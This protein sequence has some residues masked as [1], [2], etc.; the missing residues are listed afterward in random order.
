MRNELLK[1][2]QVFIVALLACLCL[3]AFD[4]S[5]AA[6][7]KAYGPGGGK[8]KRFS[9]SLGGFLVRFETKARVDS[10]TLGTGTEIDLEERTG[11]KRDDTDLML[12]GRLRFG[13]RHHLDFGANFFS[14]GASRTID[15]EIQFGDEIFEIDLDV[16]TKFSNDVYKL[17]YRYSFLKRDRVEAGVSLGVSAFDVGVALSAEGEGGAVQRSAED[18][19]API[20]VIGLH[21]DVPLGGDWYF[22]ARGEYFSVSIDDREGSLSDVEATFDWYPF[23]HFGFG[24]G[25]NRVRLAYKDVSRTE[26][27]LTYIYSGTLIYAT[28]VF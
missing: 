21:F 7:R 19:I 15:E 8:D 17:A 5:F 18:F 1:F 2:K 14:R 6:S 3:G 27:D 26:V 13:R 4:S 12:D 20:P 11:L 9:L 22:R 23:E 16:A 28:Y 10:E 24:M 25:Y